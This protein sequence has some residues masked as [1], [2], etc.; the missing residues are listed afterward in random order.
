VLSD[1]KKRALYD[2]YGEAGVK[3]AVGGSAGAYT[4]LP[5][6]SSL[7]YH[8]NCSIFQCDNMYINLSYLAYKNT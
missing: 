8:I 4:V 2:Q 3:S 6:N 1:D 5:F 7:F